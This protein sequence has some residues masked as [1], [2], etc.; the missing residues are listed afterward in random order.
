V[1]YV[2]RGFEETWFA[3]RE[4]DKTAEVLVTH[5]PKVCDT[6]ADGLGTRRPNLHTHMVLAQGV[7]P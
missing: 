5:Q 3:G 6:S 1:T 2:Y 4:S 7:E